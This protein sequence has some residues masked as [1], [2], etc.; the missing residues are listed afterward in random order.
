MSPATHTILMILVNI[1]ILYVI[2]LFF[3]QRRVEGFTNP[4]LD[5]NNNNNN[6]IPRRYP[7]F[8][9]QGVPGVGNA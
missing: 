2:Y 9:N 7:W 3:I 5:N 4:P 6:N 1:G 8:S